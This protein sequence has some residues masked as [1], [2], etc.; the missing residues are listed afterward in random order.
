MEYSD[1]GAGCGPRV[2]NDSDQS[3]QADLLRPSLPV[4]A[5][6]VQHPVISNSE[7]PQGRHCIV[8]DDPNPQ[9][10]CKDYEAKL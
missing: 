2:S 5:R 6:D 9:E 10:M 7:S 3:R 4:L 8:H 1:H